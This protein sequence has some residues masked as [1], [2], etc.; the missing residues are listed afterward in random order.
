MCCLDVTLQAGA[1][2]EER[3]RLRHSAGRAGAAV[4]GLLEVY[5]DAYAD[6]FGFD[7]PPLHDA[8]AVA[9]VAHPDVMETRLMRVDVERAGELTRGETVCD[10]HGVTGLA[11]NAHVGLHLDRERFF[12]RLYEALGRL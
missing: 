12:E 7:A 9:A 8:V 4:A 1:G 2:P 5:A 6:T 10:V 11:P 3:E